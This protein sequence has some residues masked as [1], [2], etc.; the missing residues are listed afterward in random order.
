M[1]LAFFHIVWHVYLFLIE[2]TIKFNDSLCNTWQ[3]RKQLCACNQINRTYYHSILRTMS[4]VYCKLIVY[5]SSFF[6]HIH[7]RETLYKRSRMTFL[8]ER[9]KNNT[10]KPQSNNKHFLC[11]LK[12]FGFIISFQ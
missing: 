3:D 11:E 9:T 2:E 8:L 10:N 1:L 7:S 12:N 6:T 5:F 4:N